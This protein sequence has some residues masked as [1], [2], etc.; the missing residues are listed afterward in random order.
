MHNEK[1]R[2]RIYFCNENDWDMLTQIIIGKHGN[3]DFERV[4]NVIRSEGQVITFRRI[5]GDIVKLPVDKTNKI[6]QRWC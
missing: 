2:Y 5:S 1:P 3:C 6:D 4:E